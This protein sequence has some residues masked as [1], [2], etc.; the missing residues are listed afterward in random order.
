MK[1]VRI[2]DWVLEPGSRCLVAAE[3][4]INHNGDLDLALATIDAAAEAGA[5]AVKFQNYRTEDFVSDRSLM[6]EYVS[7]D[8]TVRESQYEMFRR[9]ELP[10]EWLP[11][12]AEHCRLRRVMFFSTPTSGEGVADLV[13]VGAVVLKNGS[14]CLGNLP[15]V[16]SMAESGLPAILSTGMATLA[17]IDEAV[18]AFRGAGGRELVLLHCTSSYPTSPDD[19]HLRKISSL[20]AAFGCPVGLSDHTEG[21]VA[22]IGAVALGACIIEKHFTLD[23]SLPGPDHRFSCDLAEMKALVESVERVQQCLGSATIGTTTS[24]ESSRRQFRLSCAASRRL[25]E[26]HRLEDRDIV[27]RRPGDGLPPTA[28]EWLVGQCLRR[29]VSAGETFQAEHFG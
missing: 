7:Q 8:R 18:R 4:G 26:G 24:Q 23:K 6:Y 19:V 11:I 22:A 17:E 27:F 12:L 13:R 2:G 10:R 1:P 5:H 21:V 20:A 15:L 25:D 14:D 9:Y 29:A 28:A 3:I 16:R